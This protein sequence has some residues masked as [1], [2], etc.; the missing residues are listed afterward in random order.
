MDEDQADTS[1]TGIGSYARMKSAM[2]DNVGN[3]RHRMFQQSVDGVRQRLEALSKEVENMLNDKTDEVFLRIRQDYRSVLGAG[4]IPHGQLMPKAQRFLR[5]DIKRQ[6]KGVEAIFVKIASGEFGEE[7][8]E[9]KPRQDHSIQSEDDH[10]GR[11]A[12]PRTRSKSPS[13]NREPSPNRA[14]TSTSAD[15][16]GRS[17]RIKPEIEP[18]DEQGRQS[19]IPSVI[20]EKCSRAAAQQ[21]GNSHS[22]KSPGLE[23]GTEKETLKALAAQL[24]TSPRKSE[25]SDSSE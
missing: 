13:Q 25:N 1:D 24:G 7:D 17:P 15:A 12:N 2:D 9:N 18:L 22:S 19:A 16:A 3:E 23:I 8:G 20:L 14:E 5:K 4:D 10:E 21:G 11:A 6:I